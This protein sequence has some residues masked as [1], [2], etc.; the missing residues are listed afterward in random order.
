MEILEVQNHPNVL[1]LIKALSFDQKYRITEDIIKTIHKIIMNGVISTA[2]SYRQS[3]IRIKG[4]NFISP[5][6]CDI[7]DQM[8]DL[9]S[10][11][12]NNPD[13]LRPIELASYAHQA[14]SWIH[15]SDDGD[16]RIT[17]LLLNFILLQN[18]YRFVV[19]RKVDRKKYLDRLSK[20]D[21]GNSEPFV[22]LIARCEEQTL[23][24]YLLALESS[25]DI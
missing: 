15:P 16:G 17:R 4:A 23:D 13:E 14:I 5:A 9:V 21:V 1:K 22:N 6:F 18:G 10:F 2:W 25:S 11:I 12:N 8:K 3:Q 24:I 20:T 7:E 19:I